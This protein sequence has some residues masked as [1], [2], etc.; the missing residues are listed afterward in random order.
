[1]S[2]LMSKCAWSGSAAVSTPAPQIDYRVS[3]KQYARV[4]PHLDDPQ[5]CWRTRELKDERRGF[6]VLSRDC[7][8][9]ACALAVNVPPASR[10]SIARPQA[11]RANIHPYGPGATPGARQGAA[12]LLLEVSLP[13]R[14]SPDVPRIPGRKG[15]YHEQREQREVEHHQE[16]NW[17]GRATRSFAA[18][19][20]DPRQ[21][22]LYLRCGSSWSVWRAQA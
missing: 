2:K 7:S 21:P 20:C 13:Q 12:D 15:I 16:A 14:F 6:N 5:M 8:W 17:V 10:S 1:M 18:C 3:R 22:V 4:H 9:R 11:S 19:R